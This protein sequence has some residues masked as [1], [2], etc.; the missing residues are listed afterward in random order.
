MP[1]TFENRKDCWKRRAPSERP[2]PTSYLFDPGRNTQFWSCW[3]RK[4]FE[5]KSRDDIALMLVRHQA[6]TDNLNKWRG[7]WKGRAIE[8]DLEL[9]IDTLRFPA[10]QVFVRNVLI[11]IAI[12]DA[13]GLF[14]SG[15]ARDKKDR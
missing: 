15:A 4:E 5:P 13:A 14:E 3:V 9:Q 1:E 2:T 8:N 10:T 12:A 6:G 11:D 7:A